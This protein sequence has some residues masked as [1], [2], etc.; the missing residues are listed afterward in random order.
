MTLILYWLESAT[1]LYVC[2]HIIHL[3]KTRSYWR[4]ICPILITLF[5]SAYVYFSDFTVPNTFVILIN[6]LLLY[7]EPWYFKACLVLVYT[8]IVNIL[9]N[10]NIY[11]YCMISRTRSLE[12]IQYYI[13]SDFF[14][15]FNIT[16][17]SIIA[18][19]YI[20][21]NTKPFQNIKLKGYLL[22][23][24]VSII[25]FFLS[26]ISSLLFY[27]SLNL[28]G[29]YL[30]IIA[31]IIT[32]FISILLLIL[33][34]RLQHYHIILKERNII[35][36]KM[37]ALEERHYNEFRKKNEDLRAFRHDYN[38]H[39]TVM[40]GL[41]SQSNPEKLKNYVND[42]S[43][44][45][46]QVY[47]LS[48][49]HPVSDAIVN[50]FYENSSEN[51][52]FELEGKFP[53]NIFVNDS[54]LCVILS[55]LLKNATEAVEKESSILSPKIYI[56]LYADT[57]HLSILVENTSTH[58]DSQSQNLATTKTDS[59]NH[60]FGLRNIRNIVNKYHGYLDLKHENNTF[61]ATCYLRNIE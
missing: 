15:F 41:A 40:Q 37:L 9:S 18:K 48:T 61:K 58:F 23:I 55:N 32:I 2:K 26:S 21:P 33:Y 16:V 50:Y 38:F 60:G 14:V 39:I 17:I 20:P 36:Q 51:I 59:L 8:L 25:D 11:L 34:F 31:I 42:L 54:D 29:K 3:N 30:L 45:K 19:R 27:D 49:N 53:E 52:Q 28:M 22:I 47:Y 35:N 7:T 6:I 44:I 5:W 57:D 13:Y 46:E 43:N 24:F 1:L 12:N 10:T 56:L 4:L